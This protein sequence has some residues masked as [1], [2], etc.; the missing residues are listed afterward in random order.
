MLSPGAALLLT[1]IAFNVL[2]YRVRDALD[3]LE[4]AWPPAKFDADIPMGATAG[5][6]SV[7]PALNCGELNFPA[8]IEHGF[9]L[10]M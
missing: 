7:L 6:L 9:Q 8:W 2:G 4:H 5:I 1:T 10:Y 3:P